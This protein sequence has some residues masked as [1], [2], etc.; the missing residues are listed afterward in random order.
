MP[1]FAAESFDVSAVLQGLPDGIEA[2]E[3]LVAG[4]GIDG[5]VVAWACHGADLAV[6]Q[7]DFDARLAVGHKGL[8][9]QLSVEVLWKRKG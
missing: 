3:Q 6:D 1:V 5:E 2:A 9:G 8:L 4:A 7:V